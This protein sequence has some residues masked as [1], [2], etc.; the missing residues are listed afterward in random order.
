MIKVVHIFSAK[1]HQH[2]PSMITNTLIY[3]SEKKEQEH[4][5][6]L[7]QYNE[8][9]NHYLNLLNSYPNLRLQN[10]DTS[11]ELNRIIKQLGENDKIVLHNF[12]IPSFWINFILLPNKVLKKIIWI[13]WGS[14]SHI[15]RGV[16]G[17]FINSFRKYIFKKLGVIVT[18]MSPD[19]NDVK[20]N[21]YLK[22]VIL[23]PYYS[24][25]WDFKNNPMF[26]NALAYSNNKDKVRVKIGNSASGTNLHSESFKSLMRFKS[27][28]IKIVTPL[29][30]GSDITR[31]KIIEE[32][33]T[34][35]K[36]KYQALLKHLSQIDYAKYLSEEID[37]LVYHAE[38]QTGLFNIYFSVYCGKKIFLN[39]YN[40]EWLK[41]IGVLVFHVNELKDLSFEEF[42]MPLSNDQI[43]QNRENLIKAISVESIVPKWNEIFAV[44][45]KK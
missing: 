25:I 4:V 29:S 40:Y 42:I 32:G 45:N 5:F 35:F 13:C 3:F 41:A 15:V 27:D 23:L 11:R 2:V 26:L 1:T 34:I 30:Y 44:N 19:Y 43:I 21:F 9:A 36:D 22:N 38:T 10:F 31:K 24:R 20:K 33:E 7:Y 28:N 6:Y 8:N 12:F 18:L 37:I 14:G 39:G 17:F 16:K